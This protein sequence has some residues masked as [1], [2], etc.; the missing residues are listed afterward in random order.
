MAREVDRPD[1]IGISA[2]PDETFDTVMGFESPRGEYLGC[3]RVTWRA[4]PGYGIDDRW[5]DGVLDPDEMGIVKIERWER[6]DE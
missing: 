1:V 2:N 5:G 4:V 3:Y 6:I